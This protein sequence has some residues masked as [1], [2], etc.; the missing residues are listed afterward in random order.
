MKKFVSG[1]LSAA[2]FAGCIGALPSVVPA[3]ETGDVWKFD[4]GPSDQTVESG[5]YSVTPETEY[6]SNEVEGLRFG[7]YGQNQNDYKLK[8]HEDGVTAKK[9]QY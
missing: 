8:S 3:A 7:L 1:L 2:V 4:F 9:G 5:Y 6:N